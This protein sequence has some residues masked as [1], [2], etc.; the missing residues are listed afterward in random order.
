MEALPASKLEAWGP[1]KWPSSFKQAS[2]VAEAL[3]LSVERVLSLADGGFMPHYRIDDGEPLF[4]LQDVKAWAANTMLQECSGTH[5]PPRLFLHKMSEPASFDVTKLPAE[6]SGL[7][8][9]LDVSHWVGP[10]CGVYFLIQDREI[11]YIGQSVRAASRVVGHSREK[12]FNAAYFLPVPRSELDRIEG[13]LIRFFKP[14]FNGRVVAG[15]KITA[16]SER[17]PDGVTLNELG[18]NTPIKTKGPDEESR[19]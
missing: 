15:G 6:L 5:L 4:R 14:P 13:T 18:L 11:A 9:L 2:D 19:L 16:P 10:T 12:E 3:G 1:A 8:G 7:E 17:T